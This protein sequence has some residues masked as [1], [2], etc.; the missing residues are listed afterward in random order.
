MERFGYRDALHAVYTSSAVLAGWF[1][2]SIPA[3]LGS[4]LVVTVTDER[5]IRFHRRSLVPAAM[6]DL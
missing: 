4:E 1:G 2:C 6:S 5:L 3:L